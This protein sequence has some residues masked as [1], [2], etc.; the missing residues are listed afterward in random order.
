MA[1]LAAKQALLGEPV[2]VYN[3][4][5][6]VI[7]GK[8]KD[9]LKRYE[10]KVRRGDPHHGPYFP[11]VPRLIVRRTIRGMLPFKQAR[12]RDAYKL[13]KCFSG[14]GEK[15]ETIERANVKKIHNTN[16][17]TVK[18]LCKHLKK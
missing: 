15:M 5:L 1:A 14:A 2:N 3:S 4:D 16:Y 18:E 6:V 10:A 13:V 9:I 12:G 7:S 17:M 8:K 11:R